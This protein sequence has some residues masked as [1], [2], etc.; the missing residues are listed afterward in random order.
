MAKAP[1]FAVHFSVEGIALDQ[2]TQL[3]WYRLGEASFARSDF[4]DALAALRRAGEAAAAEMGEVFATKLVLPNDQL[5]FLTLEDGAQDRESVAQALEGATPYPLSE[6]RFDWR[7]DGETTRVAAV[8]HETLEEAEAFAREHGLAPVA[9]VALPEEGWSDCEAFFG[10]ARDPGPTPPA[11]DPDPYRRTS[12]PPEPARSKAAAPA[13]TEES[14]TPPPETRAAEAPPSF[15][16]TRRDLSEAASGTAK[17]ARAGTALPLTPDMALRA[18]PRAPRISPASTESPAMPT[19][20]RAKKEIPEAAALASSLRAADE[21]SPPPPR[22]TAP[23]A[24]KRMATAPKT[25]DPGAETLVAERGRSRHLGLVLTVLLILALLAV[26]ALAAVDREALSRWFEPAAPERIEEAVAEAVIARELEP[27]PEPEPEPEAIVTA[28]A[29]PVP[30]A[31]AVTPVTLEGPDEAGL[32]RAAPIDLALIAPAPLV[33]PEPSAAPPPAALPD[34]LP[35]REV[36]DIETAPEDDA[37]PLT[38]PELERFYAETGIWP[39]APEPSTA[40]TATR[41]DTFYVTSIDRR[42]ANSDAVALPALSGDRADTRPASQAVPPPPGL[43]FRVDERGL[44]IATEEGA[45]SPQGFTVFAGRPPVTAPLRVPGVADDTAARLALAGVRPRLRP[46]TL[47]ETAER[48]QFGGRTRQEIAGLRPRLRPETAKAAAEV[49]VPDAPPSDL[50]VAQSLR[51]EPRPRNIAALVE[52][53]RASQP[54]QVAVAAP[55]VPRATRPS[56]TTR[57]SVARA[58]T[59]E[60]AINLRRVNLIGVYGTPANRSALVR[61]ANGRFVKVQVGDRMDGGRVSA[62]GESAIRY[63]KGGRNITLEIPTG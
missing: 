42:I 37:V 43:R 45:V 46:G 54:T 52:Q 32:A 49:A 27:E 44:L 62:I 21:S 53:A 40:P 28:P 14:T 30:P 39:E 59:T 24:P 34:P 48:S 7:T 17:G 61:L 18:E 51:P 26:G 3:G 58:A 15:Q 22:K 50:A 56:G 47:A 13:E 1:E 16:T 2:W 4:G 23:A 38:G 35:D 55:A 60:S 63:V 5:K 19:P 12:E 9:F 57:A 8:A 20:T 25:P 41:L 31:K 33:E 6:L 36:L 11:R 10:A 29:G